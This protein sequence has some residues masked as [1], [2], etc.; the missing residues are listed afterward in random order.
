MS[1]GESTIIEYSEE[2]NLIMR[3]EATQEPA[4][5]ETVLIQTLTDIITPSLIFSEWYRYDGVLHETIIERYIFPDGDPDLISKVCIIEDSET[6]EESIT[7]YISKREYEDEL[8]ILE[9]LLDACDRETPEYARIESQIEDFRAQPKIHDT[10]KVYPIEQVHREYMDDFKR[11]SQWK[12]VIQEIQCS[13]Y[14]KE[15]F[16][17]FTNEMDLTKCHFE[18]LR[19]LQSYA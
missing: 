17:T 2:Y 12:E 14:I 19:S 10:Q 18:A 11:S 1:L 9:T 16:K 15:K 7:R 3:P 6:I 5:A 4:K 8:N 13:P